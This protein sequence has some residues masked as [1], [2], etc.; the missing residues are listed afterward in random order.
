MRTKI[1]DDLF[2][3]PLINDLPCAAI[4]RVFDASLT[5]KQGGLMEHVVEDIHEHSKFDDM[6]ACE[7]RFIVE[8]AVADRFA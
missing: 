6:A 3:T 7:F 2:V 8:H 5:S 4:C 1:F